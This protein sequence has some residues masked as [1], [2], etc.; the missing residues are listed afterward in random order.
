MRKNSTGEPFSNRV[1]FCLL[2]GM[3]MFVG[4]YPSAAQAPA[5]YTISTI[6][7]TGTAGFAGDGGPAVSAQI[8]DPCALALDGSGNLFIGDELNYRIRKVTADGNI[9]TVAG[10][11][12]AGDSGTGGAA[13]SA[14]I[15]VPCGMAL[16]GSGNLI[17]ADTTNHE[18]KRIA[19][20]GTITTIAGTGT[21]GYAGDLHPATQAQLNN[22]TGIAIDAGG[23]IYIADSGNHVIR[24]LTT[25]GNIQTFA[26]TGKAGY[27]GDGGPAGATTQLS[28][29]T[30]LVMDAAGNLYVADSGNGVIRKI[31]PGGGLITTIAGNGFNSYGGDGKPAT[32]AALDHPRAVSVDP[33]GNLYIA[34]TLNS[35]IRVVTPDGIINTIAG[36]GTLGSGGDGGP[37]LQAQMFFPTA[38]RVNAAG[39]IYV[40]DTQNS[41]VRLLTPGVAP[42]ATPTISS[43]VSATEFGA[44]PEVAPGSWIE[45]HGA[46]IASE[47][48][49]WTAA[50]FSGT[51]APVSLDHVSVTIA[52]QN[53][54]VYAIS[55]KQVSVQVPSNVGPGPQTL[56]VTTPGGTSNSLQVMIKA[57]QPGLYAP[58]TLVAGGSQY[59]AEFND[60]SVTFVMPSGAVSGLSSRPA[61]AGEVIVLWG[62]GF[63]A[64]SPNI[65][66]GEVVQEYNSLMTPVQF[67]VGGVPATTLYAGL[68]PDEI[69]LYQFNLVVPNVAP[70]SAVPVTFNQGGVAGA[71]TLYIA[72]E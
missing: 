9:S 28:N 8:N 42:G 44:F 43:I 48:R 69:G 29:P 16:D 70:G 33:A 54:F 55:P 72:V 25:D 12:T 4:S 3:A 32:Q 49:L 27:F 24:I 50:D 14:A 1:K 23:N 58:A 65:S 11:G 35:R 67:T 66:A 45:V 22:P 46:N 53:A 56:T 41:R 63:G 36:T 71:Q 40:A 30:G 5:A 62:T 37:A 26:G 64:V 31:T 68:A 7:G 17:F 39:N 61:H 38:V 6:V 13:T 21:G 47:A 15:R 10:T 19:T 57:T 52:G 18:I 59:T 2:A 60:A 51:N 20:S 34:D